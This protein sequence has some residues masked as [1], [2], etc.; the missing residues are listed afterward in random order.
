MGKSKEIN[1]KTKVLVFLQL[2]LSYLTTSSHKK[3]RCSF[4]YMTQPSFPRR[5][6]LLAD[7]L[8]TLD[9]HALVSDPN[10]PK[11]EWKWRASEVRDER[12]ENRDLKLDDLLVRGW[13]KAYKTQT[14]K[15]TEESTPPH[16]TGLIPI[17][18][19]ST[20]T[21][22]AIQRATELRLNDSDF[23]VLGRVG[24]G[25]FG[26]VCVVKFILRGS[27]TWSR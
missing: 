11:A 13:S 18:L 5:H 7:L 26:M 25:Q 15:S 24:E 12:V 9:H 2:P 1:I 4:T 27:D 17:R 8:D 23:D 21:S 3:Y 14:Q 20:L 22:T 19:V 10:I 6:A 16:Q